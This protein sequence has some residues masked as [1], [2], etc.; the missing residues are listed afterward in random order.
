[1][2]VGDLPRIAG[3]VFVLRPVVADPAPAP[4]LVTARE[5]AASVANDVAALVVRPG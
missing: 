5:S 3:S 2:G 1:M 4:A